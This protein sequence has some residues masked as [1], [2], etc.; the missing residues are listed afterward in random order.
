[1]PADVR[2]LPPVSIPEAGP[3]G[4][5][6]VVCWPPSVSAAV[7]G[8]G[9]EVSAGGQRG[10]AQSAVP[11]GALVIGRHTEAVW[12]PRQCWLCRREADIGEGRPD[13]AETVLSLRGCLPCFGTLETG[14]C[15]GTSPAEVPRGVVRPQNFGIMRTGTARHRSLGAA[16]STSLPVHCVVAVAGR[17][18]PRPVAGGRRLPAFP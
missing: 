3:T 2:L 12:V 7:C 14:T 4:G 15:G 13:P 6:S 18:A 11:A 5:S 1:M 9:V 10:A 17:K 16:P 8:V